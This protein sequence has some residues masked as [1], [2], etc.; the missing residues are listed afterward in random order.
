MSYF[1]LPALLQTE[2][3]PPLRLPTA[4]LPEMFFFFFFS[5]FLKELSLCTLMKFVELEAEYPLVKV[6]WKG[7]FTFPRELLKVSCRTEE[8]LLSGTRWRA[9]PVAFESSRTKVSDQET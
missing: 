8:F 6:E 1:I 9:Q 7:S 4:V 5:S 2:K 3:Q